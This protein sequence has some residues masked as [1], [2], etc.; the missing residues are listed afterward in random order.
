MSIVREQFEHYVPRWIQRLLNVQKD[1]SALLQT[2]KGHSN[3]VSA[4]AFSPDGK[5]LASASGDE[6]VKLWNAGT[7][8]AL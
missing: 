6:T 7:G 3:Y 5:L 8:A 4:V 1:W 2:L